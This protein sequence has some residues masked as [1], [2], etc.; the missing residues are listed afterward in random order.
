MASNWR[1]Y[2][3]DLNGLPL[4]PCGAGAKGK[5][6]IDPRT[7]LPLKNWQN[8][9]YT[10]EQISHMPAHVICVGTRTGP[11]AGNLLII[12]IDGKS[13]L[14]YCTKTGCHLDDSGWLITR[15]TDVNRL[16]VAFQIKDKELSKTLADI[17]KLVQ[18]TSADPKEQL[19][20]FYGTGQCI[21]LG[22]HQESGG[23]YSWR[24]SPKNLTD[25]SSYWIGLVQNLISNK[26]APSNRKS[27]TGRWK[28]CIPC[29]ICGRTERDCKIVDDGS[30]IQC[31]KGSRWH[32]PCLAKGRTIV[33]GGVKWAYVGDGKN[34]IGPCANFKIDDERDTQSRLLEPSCITSLN[35]RRA[36]GGR[37][38]VGKVN[39][40]IEGFAAVGIVLLAA[41]P[42]TGKTTLLYR[43]AE[44]IQEGTKFLDAVPVQQSPVLF[45]Q[46]DEPENIT[47]GKMSRM[48]L[49]GN[50]GIIYGL[51]SLNIQK[52]EEIIRK[53]IWRVIVVDSLTTVLANSTCTTMDSSM[54]DNLYRLN[55]LASD[56]N[57]AVI[58]TA[59]LNKPSKDGSGDR[60]KRKVIGW[61]DISGIATIS[62]A[63]NDAWGL[64]AKGNDFSL[65]ALGKRHVEAGTE[66]VLERSAEDYSWQL[67]EVTD[68]LMPNQV[69]DAK[70][71]LLAYL[72]THRGEFFTSDELSRLT[73]PRNIEHTRR[74][75]CDLFDTKQISRRK[76]RVATG[77]PLHEYGLI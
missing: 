53:G 55:K 74:C 56:N 75:L 64:T 12:D 51:D 3:P 57:V 70:H 54:A 21:V 65:H 36:R 73:G 30:F 61:A 40:V 29:P 24:G 22:Q 16:K 25:L 32:P 31:H 52:L 59:H 34:G 11:D 47:Q 63:V 28:N 60:M 20:L 4:I 71:K 37:A 66:W 58:M 50:F 62:A 18:S 48:D 5:A 27:A 7:K 13:A 68:G 19:E 43:A 42:G 23:Y 45:I 49:V 35:I 67:K 76:R 1:E 69:I 38:D 39:W 9:S 33:R 15:N 72:Q 77:R 26:Q 2:L 6:P 10:P 44:A 17:G 46:G 41:E 14:E 8:A